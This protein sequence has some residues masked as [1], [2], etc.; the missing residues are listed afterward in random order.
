MAY[1]L[2]Q[3]LPVRYMTTAE[4]ADTAQVSVRQI[5]RWVRS[6]ALKVHD[7]DGQKRMIRSDEL[8]LHIRLQFLRRS[9][10]GKHADPSILDKMSR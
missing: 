4:A 2:Q 5:Q 10:W 3:K 8:G 9:K 6:G 1:K 7:R